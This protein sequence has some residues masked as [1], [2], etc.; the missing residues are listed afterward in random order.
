M[1]IVI[2]LQGAQTA[3]R[4]RGIGRYSLSL[5]LAMARHRRDN[6]IIVAL[7]GLFPETIEPL[8]AAFDDVLPQ[9]NI[10][11]WHAPGPIALR[12]PRNRSRRRTAE[13][14]RE[15][16]LAS[17]EPD[18]VHV[19]SL[20]EGFG[21][22]AGTSIARLTDRIP[23]TVTLYDLIPHI[24]R[25]TYLADRNACDCYYEQF[26]HLRH[27]TMLLAIS[28]SS[29]Q[30]AIDHLARRPEDV[31]V[32]PC[33]AD[34]LFKKISLNPAVHA[35]L[36]NR[37]GI[38]RPFVMYTGGDDHR[39]N[40]DGLVRAYARLPELIRRN[41]QLAIV[42]SLPHSAQQSLAIL[43][44]AHGLSPDEI[45]LLGQVSDD[46]LVLL[47][48]AC[49]LFVF[50]S[51]HEGF[52]LPVLE[53]MSCG[54]PVIGASTTSVPEVIG[55]GD[56]LFDPKSDA[57][58]SAKLLQ[59]ITDD[60]FRAELARHGLE[61]AKSF[62]WDESARRA[63]AAFE[64]I[65]SERRPSTPSTPLTTRRPRLA[66]VS[67]LP[68]DRSG[69]ADYS[70]E[71]LPELSRYYEIEAIVRD[72]RT[73]RRP[74][75]ANIPLR[76][77]DWLRVNADSFD[78]VLYH[79]GNSFFH[80]YMFDLL[81]DVPGVV[82]LH[83][84]FLSSGLAQRERRKRRFR[85]W[86]CALYDSHG[87]SAVQ[88]RFRTKATEDVVFKYPANLQVLQQAQGVIVHS[89]FARHLARHWYGENTDR[90]WA[91]VP[92]LRAPRDQCDRT[93]ARAALGLTADAF[94]VCCFG[95]LGPAKLNHRVIDAW[96][97]SSLSKDSRSQLVFVGANDTDP[98]GASIRQAIER[99]GANDRIRIT[100]WAEPS[101][102]RDYLAA[103]D[104]AVQLRA[105]S[106]GETSGTV[107][108]CLNHGLP[109]IV[110]ACGA[111]AEIPLHAVWMLPEAFDDTSLAAAL[112]TLWRE[113]H[114]GAALGTRA[115]EVVRTRHDPRA[116]AD[117]YAKAIE[118]FHERS[119]AGVP[120]LIEAIAA[121]D[122]PPRDAD[123]V[124]VAA[125]IAQNHPA[126]PSARTLF[127]DLSQLV[128]RDA[129]SGIPRVIRSVLRAL[130][131][132]PPARF[133]I[134]PV[135]ATESSGGY[136]Y[137]RR[138]TLR[139]NECPT[140]WAKDDPIDPQAGDIFL[141]LDLNHSVTTSQAMTLD[142][143]RANG[144]R[145]YH[146][147]YDLLPVLRPDYFPPGDDEIYA[148]WLSAVTRFDG[149]VA[150]SRTVAD[151]LQSWLAVHGPERNRQLKISWWHLGA[152]LEASGF[153]R[154]MPPD[155]A[156][157]IQQLR[158]A[159]S[160]L[161]VGTI[162]PR[163]GYA[164]AV[165]AFEILWAS[166]VDAR[167]VLV[168]KE[169]WMV[170]DL[171][172]RI[173][174]HPERGKRLFWLEGASDEYL[175]EIYA[176]STCLIAPSE[177]EGFG[178]PLVEAACHNLPILARD[179]PVFREVAG[180]HATYFNGREPKDLA[181]AV[182]DWQ[183]LYRAGK[184]PRTEAMPRLHVAAER[185]QSDGRNRAGRMGPHVAA[186]EVQLG[187]QANRRFQQPSP[188]PQCGLDRR[189]QDK[190]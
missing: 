21:D 6:E 178:L 180:G 142:G 36:L 92:H 185:A 164:Q 148:R 151:E 81:A 122:K 163:K 155:A 37:H 94:V 61:R 19:S 89:D 106:R 159:P 187:D 51:W 58:I 15:A 127:V 44:T 83:D 174:H 126:T 147:I 183:I 45:V 84:F 30:E 87:Y 22:D 67:P 177:G 33:A 118:Q 154:G 186:S 132:E 26:S 190:C 109:T 8:R 131:A 46:D 158:S 28:E 98:Y 133:R 135:Y 62:S 128:R 74:P 20:F 47:Y 103:A 3:S 82:V 69:I 50:P 181:A 134:E 139:M 24:Y 40:L 95:M 156:Q 59:A 60:G 57:S 105:Q 114:H 86:T 73:M 149:V 39:K 52:G 176:A 153:T 25:E 41:Y 171:M 17:L 108:D 35:D 55:R 141:G 125:S 70:A 85:A 76:T 140:D 175:K 143:Y 99:S 56:A 16:F 80:D 111:M 152:D 169:G 54:A 173:R 7:N 31:V 68:P 123:C 64:R 121:Q 104:L 110:N 91:M 162:E 172:T 113:P 166:G 101:I 170:K 29:R 63:L 168:G 100:G 11:V 124:R 188:T 88:E 138:F 49:T 167:L 96:L 129:Q 116:C 75:Q 157:A 102:F 137:A 115:R 13:L 32:V 130:F 120:A 117:L 93:S 18:L 42:C 182:R 136:R 4:Y 165:S 27:A 34:S 43:A 66:Y 146:V 38:S 2:D 112:D 145:V 119:Q 71:L 72:D 189:D 1:R 10:R 97:L 150:I 65:Y 78:R 9:D 144:L 161:I 14:I 53:A 77:P 90:D 12:E 48:N 107:L 5:T 160:F 79:F 179:I 23:T 184:H